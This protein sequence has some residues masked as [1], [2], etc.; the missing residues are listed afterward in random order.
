[1]RCGGPRGNLA[2]VFVPV[3]QP[4]VAWIGA[5]GAAASDDGRP[6]LTNG[7]HPGHH[8]RRAQQKCGSCRF[9]IAVSLLEASKELP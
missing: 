6:R 1:M 3:G 5:P 4:Q 7:Q 2:A 8:R 9:R